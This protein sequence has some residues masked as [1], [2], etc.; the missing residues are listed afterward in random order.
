MGNVKNTIQAALELIQPTREL[1]DSGIIAIY[2][3]AETG[4][5][6]VHMTLKA[7]HEAFPCELEPMPRA[8]EMY[9]FEWAV[10]Y[11]GVKFFALSKTTD[12]GER[13][14]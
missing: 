4:R 7:F 6:E 5:P 2:P 3:Y 1:Y 14:V 8:S 10:W 11:E 12:R 9:P 13:D